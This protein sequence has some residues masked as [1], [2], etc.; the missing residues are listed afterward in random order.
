VCGPQFWGIVKGKG[1]TNHLGVLLMKIRAE[2]KEGRDSILWARTIYGAVA[3][4]KVRLVD[5]RSQAW[6]IER[7]NSLDLFAIP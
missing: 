3:D 7:G 6:R 4:I 5:C 1:G 2:A